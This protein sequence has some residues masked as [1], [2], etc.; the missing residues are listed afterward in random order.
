MLED[1]VYLLEM[2]TFFPRDFAEFFQLLSEKYRTLYILSPQSGNLIFFFKSDL[3]GK[4]HYI[5]FSQH[6]QVEHVKSAY[7][8]L[9][10]IIEYSQ[11]ARHY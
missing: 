2:C 7:K 10:T 5:D 6:S 4:S 11:C 9:L 8:L 1:L 3:V